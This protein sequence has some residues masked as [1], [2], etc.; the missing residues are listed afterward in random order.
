MAAPGVTTSAAGAG[1]LRRP[2]GAARRRYGE[3]VVVGS[4]A[5]CA[6]LSIAVTTGIVVSLLVPTVR[7]FSEIPIAEFLFGTLWAPAYA[8]PSFGVLPIVVGTVMVVV[9]SLMVAIP[10]GLAS[11]IYL[12]EYAP[13]RVRKVIKP[14]LEVL[15]GIPTV[16][17]GLFAL[18]YLRP[19][20]ESLFPF[21]P[22]KGQ[23]AIIVASFAVGLLTVPLIASI[24]E[25]AMRAVPHS[26]REGAY[27][28]GAN[29]LRV[30]LRVVFPAALSGI[31]ASIV[32]GGSR[33]VGETM[34]VLIAAG[35]GNPSLSFD[36]FGPVQAMTSY[37][38]GA[39]TGDIPTGTPLYDTIFAVGALLFV[40]TLGMNLL[41]VRLVRK[42]RQRYE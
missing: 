17:I 11:A 37:I 10:V 21:L 8:T 41:A 30:S 12:S 16:A 14:A 22:W 29:R 23:Y 20:G 28:L 40:M 36:P 1:A 25:D 6:L 35:A 5:F 18:W 38:G 39:A 9:L 32:L 24:S 19:L 31:I 34:V 2:L 33:A 13:S 27:A 3:A 26:L 15:A 4:I 7:F 42:Y